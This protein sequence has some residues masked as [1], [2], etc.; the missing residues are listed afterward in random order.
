MNMPKLRESL[1][2][3]LFILPQFVLFLLF[4]A[5]PV[6]RGI[7]ISLNDWKIMAV[8]QRF[9][10]V[11]NYLEIWRDPKWWNALRN[12][13]EFTVL[14]MS[15]N[16]VLALLVAVLLK[17]RFRGR[18]FLRAVLYL[19]SVLSVTVVGV[20]AFRVWDVDRGLLSYFW[21]GLLQQAPI[22]WW[23]PGT[24]LI[25]L[26]LTTVWWTFGFPMLIFLAGLHAIPNTVYEAAEIDGANRWHTFWKVTLPL[27]GPSLLFVL[28]TQFMTHMQMFGQAYQLAGNNESAQTV[29]VYMFNNSW[30][31][32]RFG[33]AAAMGVAVT[34]F[35][36]AVTRLLFTLLG[37][38]V[39]Y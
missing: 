18:N 1:P 27:L 4:L 38:R 19:P 14:V 26:V 12:S 21:V 20:I 3:Y 29:Y 30:R 24:Q 34:V 36:M 22:R 17:E 6:A 16:T 5:W 13:I 39:E 35:I 31:Y 10:G 8:T 11:Q 37:R 25:M 15:I 33:Y 28:S 23:T 9:I 7:Q 32:F 2:N